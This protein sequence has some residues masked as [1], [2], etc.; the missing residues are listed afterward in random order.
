MDQNGTFTVDTSEVISAA[1]LNAVS[2]VVGSQTFQSPYFTIQIKAEDKV[3]KLLEQPK[4]INQIN[5][6][7]DNLLNLGIFQ[8]NDLDQ[9]FLNY[10]IM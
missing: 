9:V 8:G 1:T 10:E 7:E 6:G 3:E 2:I 5:I 4:K